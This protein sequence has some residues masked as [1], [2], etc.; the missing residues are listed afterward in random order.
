[1]QNYRR[2]Y[3]KRRDTHTHKD[4]H[5]MHCPTKK[6]TV[7]SVFCLRA[8]MPTQPFL[9]IPPHTRMLSRIPLL[10][11]AN[12]FKLHND[13][14]FARFSVRLCSI[15]ARTGANLG[16]LSARAA[17]RARARVIQVGNTRIITTSCARAL[18]AQ[19]QTATVQIQWQQWRPKES[20]RQQSFVCARAASSPVEV[21]NSKIT[22][23]HIL[24]ELSI[25]VRPK[26]LMSS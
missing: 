26:K 14:S 13:Q 7:M 21:G 8:N 19:R 16:G 12:Q 10:L 25:H 6:Q 2:Q 5:L 1:M 18:R 20:T 24:A 11:G 4:T 22:L 23:A 9:K 15:R 3:T 17:E